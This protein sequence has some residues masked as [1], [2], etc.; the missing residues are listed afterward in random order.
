M[1]DIG[2]CTLSIDVGAY[3]EKIELTESMDGV[4]YIDKLRKCTLN[5]RDWLID[6]IFKERDID[7]LPNYPHS[8]TI[9]YSDVIDKIE[10]EISDPSKRLIVKPR[11]SL[12]ES[13]HKLDYLSIKSEIIELNKIIAKN[14]TVRFIDSTSKLVIDNSKIDELNITGKFTEVNKTRV[15]LPSV[16]INNTHSNRLML[17]NSFDKIYFQKINLE[18]YYTGQKYADDEL[19]PKYI[20]LVSDMKILGTNNQIKNF[21]CSMDIDEL[22][23]E[24]CTFK[25]VMMMENGKIKSL[26]AEM[27][28]FES[29]MC[30]TEKNF[31]NPNK[32]TWYLIMM[33]AKLSGDKKL[34]QKSGYEYEKESSLEANKIATYFLRYSSGFGYLPH[35]AI[36]FSMRWVV[37]FAIIYTLIEI[38]ELGW[39]YDISFEGVMNVYHIFKE[40]LYY[41]AIT[42]TTTGYGEVGVKSDAIRFFSFFEA[43]LGVSILSILVYSLTK[44]QI[45]SN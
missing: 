43:C 39:S 41:S 45:R 7:I 5:I 35:R 38:N 31:P 23:I 19:T 33:S 40:R 30:C 25:R 29:S 14:I 21:E 16:H 10:V 27:P 36:F 8:V 17:Y 32:Y 2:I 24:Q 26:N 1:V 44:S 11:T 42:F 12:I 3:E 34:F 9:E 18:Y 20:Y 6:K 13:R 37:Y 15:N 4:V 28:I 22:T